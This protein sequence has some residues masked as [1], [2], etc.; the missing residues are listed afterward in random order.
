MNPNLLGQFVSISAKAGL[1]LP[2]SSLAFWNTKLDNIE[3]YWQKTAEPKSQEKGK[4]LAREGEV[5][6]ANEC[7]RC[8]MWKNG[9]PRRIPKSR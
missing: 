8:E 1:S 2:N 5:E 3:K 4:D 7:Q 9:D 6:L